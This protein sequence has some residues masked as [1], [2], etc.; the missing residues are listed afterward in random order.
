MAKQL[1]SKALSGILDRDLAI[2]ESRDFIEKYSPYLQELINYSTNLFVRCNSSLKGIKGTHLSAFS[3]YYH[4]IQ[5]TD[6]I[7]ILISKG[8]FV[9][10]IPLLRSAYESDLSIEYM[11]KDD[12]ELRSAAWWVENM[13]K[14]KKHYELQNPS[15]IVGKEFLNALSSDETT[16]YQNIQLPDEQKVQRQITD[17][18]RHLS[19]EF[20]SRVV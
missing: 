13:L 9:A 7:E 20:L 18:D 10:A 17:I 2:A 1:K 15:T 8:C 14:R 16:K 4:L 5:M 6:G 11:L 19:K 3:L 12:F